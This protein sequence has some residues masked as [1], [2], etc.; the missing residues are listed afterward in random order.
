[1][2]F[3][4]VQF[5]FFFLPV[6]L[7]LYFAFPR[8]GRNAVLLVASLVFYT[9]GAGDLVG[10]LVFSIICNF[11][12]GQAIGHA[13]DAE[14]YKQRNALLAADI[15]VNLALLGYFK[16]ANFTVSQIDVLWRTV[17]LER[18]HWS[19]VAL[20]IGIS[21]FTFHGL[22]YC[23]DVARG[24]SRALRNIVD[25]GLYMTLFPQLVAG[26]IIRYHEIASQFS[27]RAVGIADVSEGASRFMWGLAKKV[28]IA[29]AV[30]ELANGA[31]DLP[32]GSRSFTAAWVGVLAYTVQIYFDFSGYSDMAIGLARMFG[33]KFPENFNRPYSAYSVTDFWRRWHI[34]LSNWFRDYL[35]IPLGGNVGS[36]RR[37]HVNLLIVFFATGLWHGA[38]WTFIIWGLYHGAVMLIER[39][40]GW[41][42][43]DKAPVPWLN[44]AITL[45]LV[46]VGWVMFRA[47]NVHTALDFYRAMF[48]PFHHATTDLVSLGLGR[49]NLVALLIGLTVFFVPR[50]LVIGR[51]LELSDERWV[52]PARLAVLCVVL[53]YVA[54]LVVSGT[55][56][57][58]LYFQ[59]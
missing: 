12:F 13:V 14:R 27:S 4:S 9:W 59:F 54:V 11:L 45:L 5:I 58:F 43:L 49:K 17:G 34:T 53:P 40:K 35:Y 56:S 37:T 10:L 30:A 8:A 7:A 18:I 22:S 29:D 26:P 33:F 24:R 15:L 3:S 47:Q 23:V 20:P 41:R 38:N 55:F 39:S 32:A 6:V 28:V 44:R 42:Y 21:F 46:A 16:Y 19:S 1:M 48:N 36:E 50:G 31:F 2:V 57:P 52:D 51:S 25:F